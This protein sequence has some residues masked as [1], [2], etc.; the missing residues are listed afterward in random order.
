MLNHMINFNHGYTCNK[1]QWFGVYKK[2]FKNIDLIIYVR[3]KDLLGH[4]DL[5]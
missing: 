5:E 4:D 1:S 3:D 2:R